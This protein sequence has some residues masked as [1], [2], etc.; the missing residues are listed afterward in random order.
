[1]TAQ[2]QRSRIDVVQ[3]VGRAIRHAEGKPL[4]YIV[5]PVAIPPGVDAE[6]HLA[7]NDNHRLDP[8]TATVRGTAL[9]PCSL[10]HLPTDP[11]RY[12]SSDTRLASVLY[13]IEPPNLRTAGC[14]QQ[15][16]QFADIA[17]LVAA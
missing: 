15:T 10:P 12:C 17:L 1:M 5:V 16:D 6:Q 4:G 2:P 14:C 13:S 8:A 7:I 11:A 9:Q 3:A